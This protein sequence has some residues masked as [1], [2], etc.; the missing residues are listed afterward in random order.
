MRSDFL[1]SIKQN[2]TTKEGLEFLYKNLALKEQACWDE[3]K[4]NNITNWAQ[5]FSQKAKET[6]KNIAII[7]S[8]TDRS[9]TYLELELASEKIKNFIENNIEEYQIGLN[10]HNSFLFL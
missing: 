6:P 2:N 8:D 5:L 7:E 9:Y 4:Q 10:Y 3:I 1:E